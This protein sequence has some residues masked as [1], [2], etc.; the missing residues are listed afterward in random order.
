MR[1]ADRFEF[2][3]RLVNAD[4][5]IGEAKRRLGRYQGHVAID[6]V[7]AAFGET[8]GLMGTG[9]RMA[10]ETFPI[11]EGGRCFCGRLMRIVTG[12]A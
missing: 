3:T 4:P 10:F 6:A 11:E 12:E 2:C 9:I 5:M 8:L 7:N 1:S